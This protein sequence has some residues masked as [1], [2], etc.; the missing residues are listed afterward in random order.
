[1]SKSLNRV[2]LL[3]HAGKDPQVHILPAEPWSISRW[4]PASVSK[5]AAGNGKKGPNGTTSSGTRGLARSSGTTSGRARGS[6]SRAPSALAPGRIGSPDSAGI[7][8][9]LSC[10]RSA[11]CRRRLPQAIVTM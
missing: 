6:T 9:K 1:M 3:G 2:T 5:T 8:Q 4:P 11:S 10:M 7:A